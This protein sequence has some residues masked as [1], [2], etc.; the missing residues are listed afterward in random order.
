MSSRLPLAA[1]I[2][3]LVSAHST[4][5]AAA[6]CSTDLT[7]Q[8]LTCRAP[9]F[10][11]PSALWGELKPTDIGQLAAQR[12]NTDFDEFDDFPGENEPH[13]MS[14]D[15]ENGWIFAGINHG[16]QIWDARTTPAQPVRVKVYGRTKFPHWVSDPHVSD[17]VRDLDAPNGNDNVLAVALAGDGGLSIF[18]TTNKTD[19][20]PGRYADVGKEAPQVYAAR[21]GSTD[22]AFLATKTSGL[23]AYNM[24]AAAN[25]TGICTEETPGQ[26]GCGVYLG[27]LGTRAGFSYLDGAGDASGSQH[28]VAASSGLFGR[29]LEIWKVGNPSSPQLMAS[30]LPSDFVHGVALWRKGSNYYLATRVVTA[31]NTTQARIYDVSCIAG[32]SCPATP[33]TPV[34]TRSS[35][36]GS[37]SEYIVTDSVGSGRDFLFFGSD[38]RCGTGL[39]N[40]WLYDVSTPSAAFDVTPPTGLV[41]GTQTGYWGWYY[42]RN[43][44]GF[45]FVN[46]RVG[47]FA[48]K[49][50]YRAAY[51][52][53]DIHELTSG[54][55]PAAAFTYSPSQ[56][57]RGEPINFTDQSTG[58]P[59]QW[60]WTFA[61][62]TPA[63]S[64]VKNP[65]GVVFNSLGT[66]T[67]TL[68]ATNAQGPSSPASQQLTVLEPAAQVGTVSVTP[69]PA[70]VCQN[71]SFQALGVTGLAPITHAWQV[72]TSGG[73][74]V[75]SGGNVNPFVWSTAAA[76]AG[77]YTAT[78]TVSNA[79]GSD[80]ATSPSLVLAGLPAL[81]F[82]SPGD[83]PET[84]NGPPF[85]SGL[86]QFRIQSA[87][88]TEWRWDFGDGTT[89]VWTSDPVNGPRPS[90][91]YD[92]EGDYTV[93]VAI[94]N[95]QQGAITSQETEVSVPNTTPLVAGFSQ[96][97]LFCTGVGC[98][99]DVDQVITFLDS[100]SGSPD[101]WDYDWDGDGTFED[102]GHTSP[103]GSHTYEEEGTYHP[104]LRVRR[105]SVEDVFTHDELIFV[106]DGGLPDIDVA[107]PGQGE[108]GLEIV[109]SAS[110]SNCTPQPTSYLWNIGD[111][112]HG[113]IV[114]PATGAS[115]T[116]VYSTD[117]LR[118][119]T[120][121]SVGGGCPGI[122]GSANLTIV[123][124]AAGVFANGFETGDLTAW[125]TVVNN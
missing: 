81:D 24:T 50:F 107:T 74:L 89:P 95:C 5:P 110:A 114:G 16:L 18:N 22:Y 97:G 67:V 52:I 49:Y 111:V 108:V 7:C 29:G 33:P 125:T 70:L 1:G 62:A 59:T 11:V 2:L 37:A 92:D 85:G 30:W 57:Y 121:T 35:L 87:G 68:V 32:A 113:L 79:S 36:P 61:G 83:A 20:N 109:V 123:P 10:G 105:A 102:L 103:V 94:R 26:T 55:P 106:G 99:A 51:S 93:T 28:W 12:D 21:I 41:G 48:G 76:A 104:K 72:R 115:I 46:A 112:N 56:V 69:N 58:V 101:F 23:L 54:G 78:V 65:A 44:T 71:V 116:V 80:S 91:T 19:M 90:H 60:A 3:L 31:G 66:K 25:L 86:V 6:Q 120:A 13:W 82:T 77:T 8:F 73:T 96:D 98:F 43:P 63:S 9:A 34:W 88:A 15:S 17:P 122:A 124:G 27:R 75:A 53:F 42:R 118:T 64:T 100:S 40:E 84:L 119:L 39:Q 4:A 38:D 117:G 47:K 14:I 45:N